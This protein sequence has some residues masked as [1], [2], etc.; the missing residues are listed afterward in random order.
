MS[1]VIFGQ[2][3]LPPAKRPIKLKVRCDFN[4]AE[5]LAQLHHLS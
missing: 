3:T 2:T 5:C 1:Q 4:E